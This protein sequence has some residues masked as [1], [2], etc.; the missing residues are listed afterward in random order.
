MLCYNVPVTPLVF[1]YLMAQQVVKLSITVH[2][3]PVL[4]PVSHY[5]NA[6]T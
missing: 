4:Y 2:C 1:L 6:H 3:E 5:F